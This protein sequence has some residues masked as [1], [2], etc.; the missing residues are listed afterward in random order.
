MRVRVAPEPPSGVVHKHCIIDA[1]FRTD[2]ARRHRLSLRA[3]HGRPCAFARFARYLGCFGLFAAVCALS[4]GCTQT[5]AGSAWC[6]LPSLP[7]REGFAGLFAGTTGG[8]LI[9]AGGANF[10]D[11][12]PW[13][14]GRKTWY[15]SIFALESP[16]GAWRQVGHLPRAN[17]YGVSITA[18]EGMIC[19]GGGDAEQHFREV[20]LLRWV[21]RRLEIAPLPSLPRPCAFMCGAYVDGTIYIAGGIETPGATAALNTFWSLDNHRPSRGW[22]ELEPCPG[23][24]RMLAVAGNAEG[25]FAVFSGCSLSAGSDGKPRREYLRDAWSYKPGGGWHRLA[26]LPRAAAAAPSPALLRPDRQLLVISGDDGTRVGFKPETEHPGFA[27]SLLAYDLKTGTWTEHRD[28]PFSRATAPTTLWK[29]R[30]IIPSGEIRPG[31]RTPEVWALS[32]P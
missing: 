28:G 32:G 24:P 10:P 4:A 21:G 9:V 11:R 1:P 27:T 15:D 29:G 22:R 23:G 3:G 26:D 13:D 25:S 17:A 12:R 16:D 18:A 7:D 2:A 20:W 5:P 14:G 31:Y 6:Q 8:A 30:A 19:I